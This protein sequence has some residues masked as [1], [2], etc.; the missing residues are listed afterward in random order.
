M[1]M[2]AGA[3]SAAPLEDQKAGAAAIDLV[4]VGPHAFL[5]LG[6]EGGPPDPLIADQ[7]EDRQK[8]GLRIDADVTPVDKPFDAT[9]PLHVVEQIGDI[10]I[11]N[12]LPHR[13]FSA[14]G[15]A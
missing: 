15:I 3:A 8:P 12:V 11:Q 2:G 13:L 10:G 9:R 1:T 5:A 4:D 7:F 14:I 6:H